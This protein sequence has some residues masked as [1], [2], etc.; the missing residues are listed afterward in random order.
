MK[1]FAM[2][3]VLGTIGLI[4][5]ANG[6]ARAGGCDDVGCVHINNPTENT[7]TFQFRW[8]NGAWTNYSVAP[9]QGWNLWSELRH[10]R[11]PTP[12]IRFDNAQGRTIRYSLEFFQVSR[13]NLDDGFPYDF[14]Y[15]DDG[16]RLDLVSTN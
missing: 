7:L 1:R 12:E 15:D 13:G 3:L 2:A 9:G 6:T 4:G 14:Q 16:D 11:A 8:G 10:G 5:T